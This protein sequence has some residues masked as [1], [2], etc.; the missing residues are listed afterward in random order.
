MKMEVK[1]GNPGNPVG[2]NGLGNKVLHVMRT[3]WPTQGHCEGTLH[4]GACLPGGRP[5]GVFF[6]VTVLFAYFFCKEKN[7]TQTLRALS[8]SLRF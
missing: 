4:E 7:E 6:C 3:R 5:D 8:P 1:G 2:E